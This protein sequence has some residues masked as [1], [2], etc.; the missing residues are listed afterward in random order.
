MGCIKNR[1]STSF[2]LYCKFTD[3]NL[4]AG[5]IPSEIGEMKSLSNIVLDGNY[6]SGSLPSTIG[7]LTSLN[8][9]G[10]SKFRSDV[11]ARQSCRFVSDLASA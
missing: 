10:L 9:F 2:S 7:N 4:F 3:V 1:I 8:Y 11:R 6:L 5:P